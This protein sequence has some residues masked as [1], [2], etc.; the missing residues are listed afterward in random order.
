[1]ALTLIRIVQIPFVVLL[2]NLFFLGLI[3]YFLYAFFIK[4]IFIKR[5]ENR[6]I[7]YLA[8]AILVSRQISD[9]LKTN[10]KDGVAVSKLYDPELMALF[11]RDQKVYDEII[12]ID[13]S[14]I[15]IFVSPK[16]MHCYLV[17]LARGQYKQTR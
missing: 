8:E 11:E 15:S 6:L 14:Y 12:K 2:S 3:V 5:K 16:E 7:P 13:P 17:E 1:M 4:P 10:I 9:W